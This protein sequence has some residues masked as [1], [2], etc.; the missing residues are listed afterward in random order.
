MLYINTYPDLLLLYS[1]NS[2]FVIIYFISFMPYL[3]HTFL[4]RKFVTRFGFK[5]ILC[6]LFLL[7]HY[8]IFFLLLHIYNSKFVINLYHSDLIWFI[9]FLTRR[10]VTR[11][12]LKYLA[13]FFCFCTKTVFLNLYTM[14]SWTV[15]SANIAANQLFEKNILVNEH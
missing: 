9:I 3:A 15:D 2:K 13:E 12:G 7:M 8:D 14:D 11:F 10:F 5:Y 6:W 1:Y 4:N